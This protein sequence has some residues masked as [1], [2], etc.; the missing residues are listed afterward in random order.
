MARTRK[1]PPLSKA[2][3]HGPG[4]VGAVRTCPLTA[5]AGRTLAVS[6]RT[7]TVT[8]QANVTPTVHALGERG[9][10]RTRMRGRRVKGYYLDRGVNARVR[11]LNLPYGRGVSGARRAV[12][13]A[14]G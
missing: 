8:T 9:A 6:W 14:D 2:L 4:S 3:Q 11:R 13:R 5:D 12:S 7:A 1:A 10:D